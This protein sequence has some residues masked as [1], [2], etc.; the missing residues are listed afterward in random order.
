MIDYYEC[1]FYFLKEVEYIKTLSC[2]ERGRIE[3]VNLSF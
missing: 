3:G 1:I 2:R